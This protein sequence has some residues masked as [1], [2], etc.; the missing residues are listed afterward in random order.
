MLILSI[1]S[2]KGVNTVK[3]CS[4]E[5]QNLQKGVIAVQCLWRQCSSAVV[6]NGKSLNNDC[7]LLSLKGEYE[8][9]HR[10]TV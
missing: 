3:I 2:Q 4:V 8:E 9:F 6:L 10:K 1:E 5:N 7:A